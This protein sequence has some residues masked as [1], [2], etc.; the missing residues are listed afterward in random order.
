MIDFLFDRSRW[1]SELKPVGICAG[2][3]GKKNHPPLISWQTTLAKSVMV[4]HHPSRKNSGHGGAC[5]LAELMRISAGRL[6]GRSH[7]VFDS[8]SAFA[9]DVAPSVEVPTMNHWPAAA[10]IVWHWE[11]L[12]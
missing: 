6:H 12:P 7:H 8:L 5:L 3:V 2:A 1:A 4:G 9:E 10:P 11:G